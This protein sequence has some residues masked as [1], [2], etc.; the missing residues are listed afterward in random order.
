VGIVSDV[1]IVILEPEE[2]VLQDGTVKQHYDGDEQCAEQQLGQSLVV[3]RW[4]LAKTRQLHEG[5]LLKM[6]LRV[7][8]LEGGIS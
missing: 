6:K 4:S 7:Y 1:G 5:T 3:R 2:I 8:G